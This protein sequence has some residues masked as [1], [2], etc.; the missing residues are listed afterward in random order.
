MRVTRAVVPVDQEGS[1]DR[2]ATKETLESA[3]HRVLLAVAD[4]VAFGARSAQQ[5]QRAR[6]VSAEILEPL[7]RQARL[8]RR[9]R[10]AY[11]ATRQ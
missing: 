11:S 9:V 3:G 8:D 5:V 4:L 2:V 7:G 6:E 10:R 1:E